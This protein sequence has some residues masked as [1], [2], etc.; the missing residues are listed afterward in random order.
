MFKLKLYGG[1]C[2]FWQFGPNSTTG[3]WHNLTKMPTIN[4]IFPHSFLQI[5]K[6]NLSLFYLPFR[7]Y[8]DIAL[9]KNHI[10]NN[11]QLHINGLKFIVMIQWIMCYSW[12]RN[13]KWNR[14]RIMCPRWNFTRRHASRYGLFVSWYYALCLWIHSI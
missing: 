2:A 10:R 11:F 7:L 6:P 13:D 5:I 9:L 12:W 3:S 8:V 4:H 1:R 14:Q